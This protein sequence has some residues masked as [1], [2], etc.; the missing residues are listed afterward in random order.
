MSRYTKDLVLNKEES[1][2]S[3]MV[4][5]YL[6]KNQFTPFDYKGGEKVYR[7]GDAMLEGYKYI[8][9]SYENGTLHLEAWMKNGFGKEMDLEGFAGSLQ[10]KPF[11]QSLEQLYTLLQQDVEI[12]RG[13]D[14]QPL[15]SAIPV[16]T[17]DNSGAATQ[18]LVFGVL[19]LVSVFIPLLFRSVIGI[20]PIVLGCLGVSRARLGAGSSKAGAAKAGKV[21][22]IIAIILAIVL[23]IGINVLNVASGM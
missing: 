23:W 21:L 6:K 8:K 12:P 18:A 2:V 14:G 16:T 3:F 15:P 9:W 1:F 22:S 20:I 13:E 4:N 7:A 5:D 19:A 17:V 11:K 10:K